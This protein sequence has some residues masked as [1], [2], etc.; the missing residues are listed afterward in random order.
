M[1]D[2]LDAATSPDTLSHPSQPAR[3][4]RYDFRVCASLD[5]MRFDLPA[6][7]PSLLD[8]RSRRLFRREI[9][10]KQIDRGALA[11]RRSIGT[12]TLG[13]RASLHHADHDESL[14]AERGCEI[15]ST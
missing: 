14:P 3:F 4:A 2:A 8:A 6:G 11:A 1:R 10:S 15:F 13:H 5:G 9:R 7:A 12:L